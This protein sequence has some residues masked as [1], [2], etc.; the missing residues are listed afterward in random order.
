MKLSVLSKTGRAAVVACSA[1][2]TLSAKVPGRAA[3]PRRQRQRDH[4]EHVLVIEIVLIQDGQAA[5]QEARAVGP[6]HRAHACRANVRI[7]QDLID[8]LF[9]LEREAAARALLLLARYVKQDKPKQVVPKDFA[10]DAVGKVGT[11]RSR[12]NSS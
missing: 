6:R 1:R 3:G 5:P 9:K 12:V 7:E 8:Q 11:T 2:A 4:S 10:G